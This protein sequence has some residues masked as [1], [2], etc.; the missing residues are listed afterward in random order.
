MKSSGL[1]MLHQSKQNCEFK[2]SKLQEKNIHFIAQGGV[3]TNGLK[4]EILGD[5]IWL[6]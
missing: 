2:L 4:G 5:M 3:E 1:P 6:F